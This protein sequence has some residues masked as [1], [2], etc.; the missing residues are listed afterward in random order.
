MMAQSAEQPLISFMVVVRNE[1]AHIERCLSTMLDQTL[2]PDRYEIIVV[3]GL[4][5]DDSRAIVERIIAANPDRSIRLLDNPGLIL[6]SGWNIGIKAARGKYV[7]RPDAHGEVPRDFLE[8]SLAA[9]EAHPEAAA[10]GGALETIGQGFWGE[11]IA[12]LLSSR[13]GV[14]G[15]T[16]RVGGEPGPRETVVFGLYRRQDLIEIGGFDEGLRVNQDNV[17]HA[18]LRAAGKILY[19]DPSIRSTYYARGTLKTLWQQMFRR[20]RWLVLMFKH[21]RSQNFS[22]RYYVPLGFV[23]TILALLIAGLWAPLLWIVLAGL[24]GVYALIGMAVAAGR[25]LRPLQVPAFPPAM[26]VLHFSYGLGEL[27]GFL[28]LP[29]YRPDESR[30]H[31]LKGTT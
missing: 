16:F 12:A 17:C 6:S 7:I 10:V 15:S 9:M 1:Q 20:S 19:F 11:T 25:K 23:L 18:R 24:L 2:A 14:G 4:S 5:R 27:I 31:P 21:Q 13:V 22:P 3:D 28:I 30:T 29:F 26:F 8:R